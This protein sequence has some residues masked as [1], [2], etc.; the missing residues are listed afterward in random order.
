M[1]HRLETSV[2]VDSITSKKKKLQKIKK[3]TNYPK[4]NLDY[5]LEWTN[6]LFH[7][8]Y[9]DWWLMY[10]CTMKNTVEHL[11]ISL[12]IYRC[13]MLE[14][15]PGEGVGYF[16]RGERVGSFYTMFLLPQLRGN[17]T[18]KLFFGEIQKKSSTH[19]IYPYICWETKH[20]DAICANSNCGHSRARDEYKFLPSIKEM[21]LW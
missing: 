19:H 15:Y 16:L 18:I 13:L 20:T 9:Y 3:L 11:V 8:F 12:G 4:S 14:S 17:P 6:V 5:T 21:N 10:V 1:A 7:L 2:V